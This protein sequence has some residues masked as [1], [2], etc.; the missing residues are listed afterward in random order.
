MLKPYSGK[1]G[2]HYGDDLDDYL[3]AKVKELEKT[4]DDNTTVSKKK[5]EKTLDKKI[6][7]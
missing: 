2:R 5:P 3:K 1:V 7:S 6:K 4:R